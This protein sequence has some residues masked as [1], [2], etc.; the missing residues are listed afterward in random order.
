MDLRTF[1]DTSDGSGFEEKLKSL[2]KGLNGAYSRILDRVSDRKKAVRLLRWL[3]FSA[4]PMTVREVAQAMAIE[5]GD[6]GEMSFRAGSTPNPPRDILKLCPGMFNT[7]IAAGR[8]RN[9][10]D[11]VAEEDEIRLAHF[12]VK[13]YL[14]FDVAIS[15]AYFHIQKIPTNTYQARACL[16]FLTWMECQST[17]GTK[18][19]ALE[20][21]L[22]TY[23]A[24]YWPT[25]ARMAIGEKSASQASEN[26]QEIQWLK[27]RIESLLFSKRSLQT[28]ITLFDPEW[29]FPRYDATD[30]DVASPI[31]YASLCGLTNQVDRLLMHQD[32][33]VEA[34]GGLFERPLRAACRSGFLST[35]RLLIEN[36]AVFPDTGDRKRDE[37]VWEDAALS[38]NAHLVKFLL[39]KERETQEKYQMPEVAS[40]INAM[41]VAVDHGYLD[42][43]KLLVT[44]ENVNTAT[45]KPSRHRLLE[46]ASVNGDLRVVHHLLDLGADVNAESDW[47][48]S[49]V[50]AASLE[51]HRVVVQALLERGSDPHLC[52]YS[53]GSA[54]VDAIAYDRFSIIDLL[55]QHEGFNINNDKYEYGPTLHF[56]ALH[57]KLDVVGKLL[58]HGADFNAKG[59]LFHTALQ[60]ACENGHLNI[61]NL[62]LEK[63]TSPNV[64]DDETLEETGL[65]A[66]LN[67]LYTF[68]SDACNKGDAGSIK[69]FLSLT[70]GL[71]FIRDDQLVDNWPSEIFCVTPAGSVTPVFYL[72]PWKKPGIWPRGMVMFPEGLTREDMEPFIS[73]Q[74]PPRI[75][76]QKGL[77]GSALRAAVCKGHRDIVGRL[78]EAGASTEIRGGSPGSI[79][80]LAR[81]HEDGEIELLLRD[82]GAT[83]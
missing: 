48:G 5:E 26:F 73:Q 76:R 39:D 57:G 15:H 8:S 78:L 59:G 68:L 82:A 61:V 81:L 24:Q 12:S 18:E 4:R 7:V 51:G 56:A 49:P 34:Q 36:G 72:V 55:L 54:M 30:A 32:T 83:D 21:P 43:T 58:E 44:P 17:P 41:F 35:V 50:R 45:S 52:G 9:S 62:L 19:I 65:P 40:H 20:N 67:L 10:L 69:K 75:T 80:D 25:H 23:S 16:T 46:R 53:P 47:Y 77:H 70:K 27:E 64:S 42:V 22:A 11:E 31:Y 28:W 79:L 66:E 37:I 2:P 38:G 3:T 1:C 13:Q 63:G 6:D 60:S 29:K 33:N 74:H 71:K 14:Q